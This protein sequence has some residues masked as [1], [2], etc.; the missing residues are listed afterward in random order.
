MIEILE[1][2]SLGYQ[3]TLLDDRIS[4]LSHI[5]LQNT[6]VVQPLL[7]AIKENREEAISYLRMRSEPIDIASH[8]FDQA[9]KAE[10]DGDL[11]RWIRL[12]ETA[13]LERSK[14]YAMNQ[15]DRRRCPNCPFLGQSPLYELGDN[16]VLCDTP[17]PDL[18][19]S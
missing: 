4:Y 2:E 6:A 17:C 12:L 5:R 14:S 1:L 11:D 7:L 10:E 15:L 9:N 19:R 16:L 8:L 18:S 3:F 13:S